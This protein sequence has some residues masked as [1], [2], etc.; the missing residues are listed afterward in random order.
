M[1]TR[2][3]CFVLL[4]CVG[5][6][7][8]PIDGASYGWS[9]PGSF[10]VD[11]GTPAGAARGG[12]GGAMST[13]ADRHA[14][15]KVLISTFVPKDF[16]PDGDL[17]KPVWSTAK[18]VAFDRGAF[19]KTRYPELETQVASLWT[20]EYLYL[21]Y[22]CKYDS[23]NTF[24]GEDPSKERW[25]L[26]TRDVVEAFI[27]PQPSRA[28]HYYEFEVAPNNQWLDLEINF[29]GN[30]PHPT[31]WNSGF[32]HV[33]RIDP[34]R[35]VWTL[36]MRIPVESMGVRRIETNAEWRINLFRADGPPSGSDRKFTSWSPLSIPNGSFHQPASFGALR[37]TRSGSKPEIPR[38]GS[39]S[40]Q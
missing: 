34:V 13:E 17:G 19:Q 23:L 3:L 5:L 7:G 32:D 36:E 1:Y 9:S 37:F 40:T 22:W 29:S 8:R 24:Q 21:A 4:A 25:E 10:A 11:V 15:T 20:G 30:Q 33:T 28:S 39:S 35:H 6:T 12:A 31:Q 38:G 2:T 18:K 27:N 14:D 16:V 26:W